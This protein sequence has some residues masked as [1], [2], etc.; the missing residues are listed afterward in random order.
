MSQ[1]MNCHTPASL[2]VSSTMI[3]LLSAFLAG[4]GADGP[5]RRPVE[6]AV[7]VDGEMLRAGV[8]RFIPTGE[9]QGPG[10][11]AT[12]KDGFYQL[13]EAE[14]P[15]IGTQ[16]VEIEALDYYGFAL[17][18]ET[19]YVQHVERKSGRMPRNPIHQG[20]NRQSALTVEVTSEGR[21]KFDFLLNPKGPEA[22]AQR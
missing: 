11:V 16:R 3:A 14:G 5:P 2:P 7:A 1:M 21:Q 12:I 19:A 8:I 4:C 17:D 15:V 6:G 9:T 18:D 20:Y 13:P 22:V 10:A